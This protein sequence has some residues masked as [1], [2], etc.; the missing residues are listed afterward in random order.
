MNYK[1]FVIPLII[2]IL[3][4]AVFFIVQPD[5]SLDISTVLQTTSKSPADNYPENEQQYWC[6]SEGPK[7]NTYIKEYEIPT[8]CTKPLGII[9]DK[10][11]KVWF[12]E[13]NT[14]NIGMFDP[15]K[16]TFVEYTNEFWTQ[17]QNSMMWGIEYSDDNEVWFTDDIHDAIW[18]FSIDEEKFSKYKFPSSEKGAFPQKFII[19]NQKFF[20]N[21]FYGNKIIFI[22]HS[23]IDKGDLNYNI[24][25]TPSDFFTGP[26]VISENGEIWFISWKFGGETNLIKYNLTSKDSVVFDLSEDL[27]APNGLSM[28]GQNNLWI[29]DT[30][31]SSFFK[32]NTDSEELTKYITSSPRISSF[33]N[34]SGLIKNPTSK[35]YW[36]LIDESGKLWFNEQ[37]ANMLGVFDF[38]KESL[39]EYVIPSKNPNWT[40]C[41]DIED[42]GVAQVFG[43]TK[44][45]QKVWF[46]EWVE[47]N[48]G[49]LD[50]TIPLPV[51]MKIEPQQIELS[52]GET[53][54]MSL[55]IYPIIELEQEYSLT[56]NSANRDISISEIPQQITLNGLSPL[57]FSFE[58]SVA[59]N[60]HSGTYKVLVGVKDSDVTVSQFFTVKV[61]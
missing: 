4:L 26:P 48:I 44:S 30:A 18:K 43:F 9:L 17:G 14:G 31:T 5:R 28:D 54:T 33:G 10:T 45:G 2:G 32:F 23:D 58:V 7:S 20:I 41:G 1:I 24:I 37:A 59:N 8:P 35:P 15:E 11:G 3:T 52:D 60:T 61:K 51:S 55:T 16:E 19:N 53:S 39:V 40:D 57:T 29:T 25:E 56:T 6:D 13:T 50:T 34:Y 38:N 42:C 27:S 12:T 36:N 49:V 21:D 22:N 47:N 46:T